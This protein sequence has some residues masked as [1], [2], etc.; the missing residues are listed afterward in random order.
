MP[1]QRTANALDIF[2]SSL[3]LVRRSQRVFVGVNI[4]KPMKDSNIDTKIGPKEKAAWRLA[5]FP[6]NLGAVS[7]EQVE[8]FY[9]YI[10]KIEK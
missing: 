2:V 7:E 8:K 4:G 3:F 6:E 10:K 1:Y 9:E 5:Y